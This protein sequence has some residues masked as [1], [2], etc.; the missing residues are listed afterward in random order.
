MNKKITTGLF[1]I[2]LLA[3]CGQ[4]EN[5]SLSS[6]NSSSSNI[7]Q[8]STNMTSTSSSITSSSNSSKHEHILADEWSQNEEGH[9]KDCTC[10]P[11]EIVII[12][13]YDDDK[14]GLCDECEY[15]I[16][17]IKTYT[18]VVNDH[19]NNPI[20]GAEVKVTNLGEEFIFTTNSEGKVSKE[21]I[22]VDEVKATLLSVPSG[23]RVS[24]DSNEFVLV[25]NEIV[26]TNSIDKLITYTIYTKRENGESLKNAKVEL[27]KDDQVI[28]SKVSL[29]DGVVTFEVREDEYKVEITHLNSAYT[30]K[31]SEEI[32]LNKDMNTYTA[33]FIENKDFVYYQINIFDEEGNAFK[34][35]VGEYI[36]GCLFVFD[37]Y[38]EPENI[39]AINSASFAATNMYNDDYLLSIFTHDGRNKVVEI[40]KDDP[41]NIDII[42]D[43]KESVG[44]SKENPVLIYHLLDL[45]YSEFKD[46]YIIN[47]NYQFEA[48]EKIYVKVPNALGK[49]FSIDGSKFIVSYNDKELEPNELNR[50]ETYFE[51]VEYGQ[52][53]ILEITA[54]EKTIE[55]I[56]FIDSANPNNDTDLSFIY[57]DTVETVKFYYE[58]QVKHYTFYI[59]HDLNIVPTFEVENMTYEYEIESST[60]YMLYYVKVT[61]TAKGEGTFK[62]IV[63][64][65]EV[66]L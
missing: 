49:Y 40:K 4:K 14:N 12:E 54:K 66:N 28:D 20:E 58:G 56:E 57:E 35:E 45:P 50:I 3:G 37:K 53:V 39:L 17:E 43:G 36:V 27:K 55:D 64:S 9:Y 52:D 33:I 65:L 15:V 6:K 30:L 25:P 11:S 42:F 63:N 23:Y 61:S 8:E 62:I 31:D 1:I 59:N 41:S 2:A 19:L 48:N 10:H 47:W 24:L 26:Y 38:G 13:H 21:F 44:L 34:P 7:I 51:D 18:F 60:Y 46:Y 16:E 22:Y 5:T 32:V 29:E